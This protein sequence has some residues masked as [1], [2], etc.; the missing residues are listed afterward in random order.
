NAILQHCHFCFIIFSFKVFILFLFIYLIFLD[1]I[2][3]L[4]PRLE[5]SGVVSAHCNLCLPGSSDSPA[6]ASQVTVIT[7]ARHHTRLIFVFFCRDRVSP[8]CADWS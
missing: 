6:S 2:S 8:C 5:C 4:L 1:D 3:P 7:G